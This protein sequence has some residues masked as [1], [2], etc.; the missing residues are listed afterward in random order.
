MSVQIIAFTAAYYKRSGLAR[1]IGSRVR[2]WRGLPVNLEADEATHGPRQLTMLR[3][4]C[5]DRHHLLSHLWR[6]RRG[7]N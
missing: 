3:C 4:A 2:A 5:E 6:Q 1:A 7:R